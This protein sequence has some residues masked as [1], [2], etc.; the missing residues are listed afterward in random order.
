MA[1]VHDVGRISHKVRELERTARNTKYSFIS[2]IYRDFGD[3]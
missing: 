3:I 2:A 1:L